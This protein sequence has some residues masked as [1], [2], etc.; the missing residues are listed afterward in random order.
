MT[1]THQPSDMVLPRQFLRMCRAN[2]R[3]PKV[4]DS[5]GMVLSGG[6]LL[7]RTLIFRR[8]L[9]RHVL[10]DDEQY[11]GLLLPPSVPGVL[12][13]AALSIDR[14]VAVNL[15]YATSS[16]VVNHCAAQCGIRHLLTSRKLIERLELKLD[17]E[18]VCLEDL[19]PQVTLADKLAATAAAWFEPVTRLERRLGLEK[20]DSEDLLSLVFTSGSTG[21]PKGVMLTHGNIGSNIE[22]FQKILRFRTDDVLVGILPFFHSFGYTVTLWTVLCLAPKGVYHFSPLDAR[23]VGKLIRE[24]T[25]TILISTPTFLRTYHRRC[26]AEDFASL[27]VVIAGAEKL[28]ADLI[29][30]FHKKFGVR[31]VEGYGTTELSPVVGVNIPHSRLQCDASEA[32]R[33]GSVGRPMPGI[34]AKV[35]D[36]D[37]GGDLGPDRSGMLLIRG[38]NVM[39][40]YYGIPEKTAEVIHD[41][42]YTTGDVAR[43]DPDGFIYITGRLSRFSK[44]GGEMVPHLRIEEEI[45]RVLNLDDEDSLAVAVTGVADAKKG[46]RLVVLHAGLPLEPEEICRRLAQSGLPP[47][48]IPAPDSFRQV[49]ELPLLASGKL[50]LRRVKERAREE[51]GD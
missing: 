20:I 16:E 8:L 27:D 42:W 31:P 49:D 40:G 34:E 37:T 1:D 3:R 47:I 18:V 26:P 35:I 23:P 21:Q 50:D 45:A 38:P 6:Q 9:R 17:A 22:A 29:N 36:L 44:I 33:E 11:V 5:S 25:G 30:A 32:I 13:N 48:W 51:F 19:P 41:G 4:A 7:T 15:N 24:H 2:L 14:R 28:P 46:E 43:I 39:K 12:A 10:A